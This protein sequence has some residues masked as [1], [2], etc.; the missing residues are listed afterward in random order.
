[1]LDHEDPKPPADAGREVVSAPD[2]LAPVAA[3]PAPV[4]PEM[5]VSGMQQLQE[6]IPGFVQLSLKQKRSMTRTAYLDPKFIRAGIHAATVWD[7]T[8]VMLKRSADDLKA[9]EE[10]IRRWE[11]AIRS[12]S[13]ILEGMIAANL[14]RK[15]RLGRDILKLYE[16]LGIFI[17]GPGREASLLRPYYEEM[18]RLYKEFSKPK[19]QKK[20]AGT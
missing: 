15:H 7:L 8:P 18:Q 17:A 20:K 6:R 1:M 5:I 3:A 2:V 4:P 13:A 12:F 9:D 11:D 16:L 19:K 14:T 10:D